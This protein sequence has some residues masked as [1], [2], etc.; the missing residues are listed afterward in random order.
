M[1]AKKKAA[2][3]RKGATKHRKGKHTFSADEIANALGHIGDWIKL[4]ERLLR[5]MPKDCITTKALNIEAAIDAT[6]DRGSI[7]KIGCP[8]SH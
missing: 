8:P 2:K 3:K 6:I 4:L 1:P 7:E 5:S